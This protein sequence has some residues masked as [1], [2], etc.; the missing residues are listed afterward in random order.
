M[1]FQ[2]EKEFL[3]REFIREI[4]RMSPIMG[5]MIGRSSRNLNTLASI[6]REE[7]LN[8]LM[9]RNQTLYPDSLTVCTTN[10]DTQAI[11]KSHQLEADLQM[12]G[13]TNMM[14]LIIRHQTASSKTPKTIT[15]VQMIPSKRLIFQKRPMF[16]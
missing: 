10:L 2:I 3:I 8:H 9:R 5:R 14:M 4:T 15:N 13:A 11:T 12:T 7:D 6:H 16:A 1:R